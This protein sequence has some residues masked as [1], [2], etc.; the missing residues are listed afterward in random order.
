MCALVERVLIGIYLDEEIYFS[1]DTKEH[2]RNILNIDEKDSLL[3][4]R[5]LAKLELVEILEQWI[6]PIA[7]NDIHQVCLK[8]GNKEEK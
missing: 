6:D 5:E 7:I 3:K 8:W 1:E 4:Q 2:I